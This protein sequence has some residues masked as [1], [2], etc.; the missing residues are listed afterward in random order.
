MNLDIYKGF[1][2]SFHLLS[3]AMTKTYDVI[4]TSLDQSRRY[5]VYEIMF[6]LKVIPFDQHYDGA[7]CEWIKWQNYKSGHILYIVY[8][9]FLR[10][11]LIQQK[12]VSTLVQIEF[13]NW[14]ETILNMAT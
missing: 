11:I 9:V 13:F 5:R 6:C 2:V 1:S 7:P 4:L 3:N 10:L 12:F 14:D 8:L